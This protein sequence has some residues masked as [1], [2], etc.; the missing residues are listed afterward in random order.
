MEDQGVDPNLRDGDGATPLHFA[1]SRGHL[2]AVRWLLSVGAKLSLDKYGKSPIND[3]AENQQTECLNVLVQH[4]TTPDYGDIKPHHQTK[5]PNKKNQDKRNG[6]VMSKSSS[7]SS[8]SEPFYLHPPNGPANVVNSRANTKEPV[9][10][11]SSAESYYHGV[12]PNDGLFIN[13]MRNGSLSPRSPSGSVSGESFFLHD[14]QEVIYN[15][16]KD[17]F[18]SNNSNNGSN[19]NVTIQ[20]QVHS[21]SSGATSASDEDISVESNT[22]SSE[23]SPVVTHMQVKRTTSNN[24]KA[25]S[26]NRSDHDYEDIYLVREEANGMIKSKIHGRSRSRDSGSHSRSASA[27]SNRSEITGIGIKQTT[28]EAILLSKR[29]KIYEQQNNVKN[30]YD[31]PRKMNN[32][33]QPYKN[34]CNKNN[35]YDSICSPDDIQERNKMA[36]KAN[37]KGR[38]KE[39]EHRHNDKRGKDDEKKEKGKCFYF[40]FYSNPHKT[41]IQ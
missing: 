40:N 32:S 12:P 41:T 5:R 23:N 7:G 22:S 34:T 17:L 25:K 39:K 20:A 3:A 35:T 18:S 10:R 38:N 28:K 4:G 19:R 21:S 31:F 37:N 30:S 36:M 9:Y 8:D 16:V 13:P 2:S 24:S 15:R 1:A 33:G 14:P 29:N 26:T 27:S 11:K 6:T